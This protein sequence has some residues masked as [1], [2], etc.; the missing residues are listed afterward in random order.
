MQMSQR[1]GEL[2]YVGIR[3]CNNKVGFGLS[4]YY[5]C[6][7]STKEMKSKHS[8]Q[9]SSLSTPYFMNYYILI[10]FLQFP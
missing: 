8:E 6:F 4:K 3:V 10:S 7:L 2:A 5:I 9:K 1:P